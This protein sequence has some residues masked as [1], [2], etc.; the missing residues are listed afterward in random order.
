MSDT[1]LIF[2]SINSSHYKS[3][4]KSDNEKEVLIHFT[5][6]EGK[7]HKVKSL[8]KSNSWRQAN[9]KKSKQKDIDTTLSYGELLAQVRLSISVCLFVLS[10]LHDQINPEINVNLDWEIYQHIT[11]LSNLALVLTAYS[12]AQRVRQLL[13]LK[14]ER[15][16]SV[17][18]RY[19][20]AKTGNELFCQQKQIRSFDK[21]DI[22]LASTWQN[23]RSLK[24]NSI[25]FI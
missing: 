7:E 6:R 13:I 16:Y 5:W 14:D 22:E 8:K 11:A 20:M 21:S 1:I 24:Q 17:A 9:K 15:I 25:L 19:Y 12:R 3:N 18:K 4:L 10:L 2:S 23:L